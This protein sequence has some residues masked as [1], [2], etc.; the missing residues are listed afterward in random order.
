MDD[1]D[2]AYDGESDDEKLSI[3][4]PQAF[5]TFLKVHGYDT[6]SEEKAHLCCSECGER[7]ELVSGGLGGTRGGVCG[8]A[9]TPKEWRAET[10]DADSS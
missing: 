4:D 9:E 3:A 8:C 10:I 7:I 1:S 2:L 5:E 6:E